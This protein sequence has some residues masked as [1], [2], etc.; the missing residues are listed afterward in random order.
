MRREIIIGVVL[1]AMLAGM[2]VGR[3]ECSALFPA[4]GETS[5]AE[6]Q[7]IDGIA[8]R[9]EDDVITESEVNELAAFQKLVDGSS[10]PRAQLIQELADQWIVRGEAEAAK[11]P[12]PS[13]ETLD[14]AYQQ[15]VGQFASAQEFKNRCAAVGLS[16]AA[17]RRMLVQQL[18]LSRFLD[19]RFRTAAQVSDEEIENYYNKEF[20]P[21]LKARGEA[22]PPLESV[23]GTIREVLVQREIASRANEWLDETRAR[24][25]IDVM[26][27]DGR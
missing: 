22:V 19:F 6:A 10:K 11:Y 9:I 3:A 14:A 12:Q 7:T 1:S 4:R 24:L 13:Q 25:K 23:Q 17:V 18:Y 16:D 27:E 5:T 21:Q 2:D 20:A 8:A 26:P 15:L